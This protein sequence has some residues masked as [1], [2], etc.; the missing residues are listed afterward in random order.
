MIK[1]YDFNGKHHFLAATAIARI[2]ETGAK[3]AHS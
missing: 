1:L 3:G 2:S